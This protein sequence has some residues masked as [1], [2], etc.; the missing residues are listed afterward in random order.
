MRGVSDNIEF[1]VESVS[2][3]SGMTESLIWSLPSGILRIDELITLLRA[4]SVP[5]IN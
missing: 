3:S 4:Y 5:A 2:R 1:V